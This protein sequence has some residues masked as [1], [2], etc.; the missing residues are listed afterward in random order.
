MAKKQHYMTEQ[1]RYKLEGL[2]AAKV[3]PAEA[4]RELGFT[5]QTIY[6]EIK[7]GTYMH[8]VGWRD[9]PRYSAT[10]GQDVFEKRQRNKGRPLK[11]GH[12]HEYAEYLDRKMYDE[13]YSPAAA[14]EEA[15]KAGYTTRL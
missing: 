13:H 7:R 12:D 2:L 3:S 9:V 15:K 4:A 1:E 10:K 14:L 6:N 5:V 8:T 11:I